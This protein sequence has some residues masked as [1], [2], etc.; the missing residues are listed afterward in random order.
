MSAEHRN[1]T[2]SEL[3][4]V[5]AQGVAAAKWASY[6]KTLPWK[7]DPI[8]SGVRRAA[9]R[10][11]DRSLRWALGAGSRTGR[12]I[13][14]AGAIG[15]GA[16]CADWNDLVANDDVI[17]T[18]QWCWR[19]RGG[20]VPSGDRDMTSTRGRWI[21]FLL[22][23][24]SLGVAPVGIPG[25]RAQGPD[26]FQ[27][28]N[29]QFQQFVRPISP[30]AGGPGAAGP[31]G[32]ADNQYQQ[33]LK[34]LDGAD[35]ALN[36]R[37]GIGVQYWKLRSDIELDKRAML[38]RRPSRQNEDFAAS[39]SQKYMAYFSE[40]N[41]RKRAI[42]MRDFATNRQPDAHGGRARAG[43]AEN[44]EAGL[45]PGRPIRGG[46]GFS[47]AGGRT[48]TSS[49]RDSGRAGEA[50]SGRSTPPAPPPPRV[51][52]SGG[53]GRIQRRPSDVLDRSRALG[54]DLPVRRRPT[55]ADRRNA[56]AP[57]TP[58]PDN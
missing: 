43:D 22:F 26:P 45:E 46:G 1:S 3:T 55:A 18:I 44:G 23:G 17:D 33:Y 39:I 21:R 32:R 28:Y 27:P 20:T 31:M 48:G 50:A 24:M 8:Q 57:A 36:Q 49:A 19:M 16:R 53:T 54:D 25:A 35:R 58:S 15:S 2:K 4:I 10:V 38:N 11:V 12:K 52:N 56:D 34:E 6:Q 40:D 30:V 41:P 9:H 5:L 37:Y 13:V 51:R 42:L 14:D 47:G 29:N 7:D